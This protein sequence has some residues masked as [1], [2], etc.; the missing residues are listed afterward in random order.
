MHTFSA[1]MRACIED[2]TRCHQACLSTAMSHCLEAGGPHVEPRHFRLM[3]ACAEIC[4]A[5]ADIML[6]GT[7]HHRRVCAACAEICDACAA[8]C[9]RIGDMQD[10]V[11]A[12]RRCAR[13]CHAMAA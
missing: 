10:C 1:E 7:E 5:A 12:C 2:C 9:E 13:S 6:I 4:R 3:I 11:D 8:D